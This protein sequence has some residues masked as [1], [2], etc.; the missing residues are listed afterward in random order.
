V[1]F[2][3]SGIERLRPIG[4]A[5]H[6]NQPMDI[7]RKGC[8]TST[9]QAIHL[10]FLLLTTNRLRWHIIAQQESPHFVTQQS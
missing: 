4:V 3:V 2:S 9:V 1:R 8:F 10:S 6:I 5:D 7:I